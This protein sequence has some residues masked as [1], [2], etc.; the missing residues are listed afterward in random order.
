MNKTI[1]L[2]LGLFICQ[3]TCK[4]Q[5]SAVTSKGDE[6]ILYDNGTWKYANKID[7]NTKIETNKTAFVKGS[8]ATFKVSSTNVSSVGINIDP[9]KWT[10]KKGETGEAAEFNFELKDKEAYGMVITEKT[11]VPLMT[12]KGI[13]LEN[14]KSAAPDISVVKQEYRTVNGLKVFYM[15]MQGTIQG[16]D[17]SYCGYYYSSP[18]GTVQFLT[19][20]GTKLLPQYRAEMEALLNGLVA[21]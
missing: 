3:I 5:T 16:I 14:A 21:N 4:A 12:L 17:I 10:F 13:A 7:T 11:E 20:C 9:K 6:V 15:Q 8:S 19:Y 18:K 1:I 2:A